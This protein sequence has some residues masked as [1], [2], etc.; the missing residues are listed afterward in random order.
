VK[1]P[2][3]AIVGR[4]NVGKST[5]FNRLISRRQAIVG[6]EP[7]ITRD[8]HYG[9]VEWGGKAFALVDTGGY[10]PEAQD[11][12]DLAVKEQVE[13]AI[14]ESDLILFMVDNQTGITVTDEVLAKILRTGQKK[15]LLIVNKVDDAAAEL[16]VDQF[17]KLGLGQ[18]VPVSAMVGRRTGD[19]LDIVI[20]RLTF[21]ENKRDDEAIKLAV[22]GKENVGKS[23]FVNRLLNQ[24]RLIVTDIPGTTRDAIDSRFRYNERDYI[25]IDTAGLK[26]RVKIKENILF[27]S[28]MRTYRSIKRCDVVLYM[29]EANSAFSRQDVQTLALAAEEYKGIVCLFNK[30]DLVAKD[31][32]TSDVM[33]REVKQKLGV[34]S[35]IPFLFI[36]VTE[37]QRLY[38]AIDLATEVYQTSRLMLKTVEL[39]DYFQ[40][41]F[42]QTPPPAKQGKEVK[43]NYITQVKANP[44]VFLFFANHPDLIADHYRRFLENKLREKF[45]FTGVPI[46]M[47]FR[48]K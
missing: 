46:V 18:P 45:K 9:E 20:D 13:I 37:K 26:K 40:N 15:V 34:M 5:F 24:Q 36:S 30:W 4:P 43:I 29:V 10:L 33:S 21:R 32:R 27:Y 44:P 22:I 1:Q 6:D 3:V 28:N 39:N 16:E 35:F 41:I 12:I 19:M 47:R 48:E 8:R 11:V 38:K 14:A 31:H 2:I 7:G 42:K 23:S 17:Y 25:L